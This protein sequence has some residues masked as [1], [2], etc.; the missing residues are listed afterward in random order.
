MTENP[1]W[2]QADGDKV[3]HPRLAR[4]VDNIWILF[5]NR[6]AVP[7][8]LAILGAFYTWGHAEIST[9]NDLARDVPEL[10]SAFKEFTTKFDDQ[11]K[12]Q[13]VIVEHVKNTEKDIGNLRD[14]LKSD[15][16]A[17]SDTNTDAAATRA[18]LND[19]KDDL[20]KIESLATQNLDVSRGHDADI[21][22]TRNAVAPR[23]RQ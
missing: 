1:G 22:A 5:I 23:D 12:I 16:R 8:V 18:R 13:S 4:A 6:Y 2:M 17:I 15:E 7:A 3:K 9:V 11:I 19:V 10:T 14:Q 21:K 20:E